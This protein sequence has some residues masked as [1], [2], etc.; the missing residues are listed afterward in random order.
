MAGLGSERSSTRYARSLPESMTQ[1]SRHGADEAR[2]P[3]MTMDP[4]GSPAEHP[5]ESPVRRRS[6]VR[7][8][9]TVIGLSAVLLAGATAG[10]FRWRSL[11]PENCYRRGY[12][13]L[14]TGDGQT[15]VEE[16]RRLLATPGF[17]AHGHLLAGLLY[18][19]SGQPE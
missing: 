9:G 2:P 14:L 16:S 8:W 18:S 15:V 13:A 10:V 19:K 4:Q 7:L 5:V 12:D 3:F 17:E 1:S 6:K 11:R